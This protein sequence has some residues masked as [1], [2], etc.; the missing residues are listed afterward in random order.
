ML[1]QQWEA[2]PPPGDGAVRLIV[3]R[4][5]DGAHATPE[6]AQLSP[7]E[8]LVGDRWS[9]SP[10]RSE[11]S[12][13]SFIDTRVAALLTGGGERLHLPGD[14]FHV[15][16]DLSEASLPV[17]TRLRLGTAVVEITAKPHAGCDKFRARLGEDALRW[18]N[19]KDGRGRRLRGVY[20]RIVEEGEVTV[21]DRLVRAVPFPTA[22]VPSPR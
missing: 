17:G 8:A 2:L 3:L 5:G 21:G 16:F 6:R 20:A 22:P 19:Q 10:K 18:V 9:V 4:L 14:N 13:V 15:D 1:D 12:H 7:T 11:D